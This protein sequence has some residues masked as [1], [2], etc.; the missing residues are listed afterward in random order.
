MVYLR[1]GRGKRIQ[2]VFCPIIIAPAFGVIQYYLRRAI[3]CGIG[4]GFIH[5]IIFISDRSYPEQAPLAVFIEA[6]VDNG[7]AFAQVVLF[8]RILFKIL[9]DMN[10]SPD[11]VPV[12]MRHGWQAVH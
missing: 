8:V 10:L 7:I 11:W 12:L 6:K 4:Q 9:I 1:F 3:V 2:A 5:F